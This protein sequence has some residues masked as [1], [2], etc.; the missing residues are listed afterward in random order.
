MKFEAGVLYGDKLLELLNHAKEHRYA[1]PAVNVIGTHSINAVLECAKLMNSP[2]MIQFSHG[3][4]QFVAGKGLS[5][6]NDFAS[7]QGAI[8]GAMH[9]HHMA[10]AYGVPVVLHT[11]HAAKKLL[12]WIDGLLAAGE[13]Y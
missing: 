8:S 4:A 9:V 10:K 12:A 3:G 11:D 1:L 6:Q 13:Q 2:V 5:N 7:I